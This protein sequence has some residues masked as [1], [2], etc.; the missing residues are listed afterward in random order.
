MM[1]IRA[2]WSCPFRKS[3][4]AW[5]SHRKSPRSISASKKNHG[6]RFEGITQ[7]RICKEIA[8]QRP[9]TGHS[10]AFAFF[11]DDGFEERNRLTSA[12]AGKQRY[13]VTSIVMLVQ[14]SGNRDDCCSEAAASNLLAAS[15]F[16]VTIRSIVAA[17]AS[18]VS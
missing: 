15:A 13:V 6:L 14:Y 2:S 9:K 3:R 18:L 1:E 17:Y 12:E 11:T 8:I 16:G 10:I 4:P 5:G 7:N